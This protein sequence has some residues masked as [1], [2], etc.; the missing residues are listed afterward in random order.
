MF[1]FFTSLKKVIF[2][3]SPAVDFFGSKWNKR[4][5]VGEYREKFLGIFLVTRLLWGKRHT[6]GG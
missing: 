4:G 2:V 1:F 3:I 6:R 5:I